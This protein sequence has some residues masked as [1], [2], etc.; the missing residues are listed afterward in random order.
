MFRRDGRY[1]VGRNGRMFLDHDSSRVVD[2]HTGRL[3]ISEP[4]L[5]A[6][7]RLLQR[8]VAALEPHGAAYAVLIPPN[9][10]SVYPEDLPRGVE[11][12]PSRPIHSLL[13]R[14]AA[15]GSPAPV[16]YPLAE[17]LE[18]KR[19]TEVYPR[20]E[21][22]WNE[23]GAFVAY[24][25]LLDA[26]P[27]SVPMRRLEEDQVWFFELS[28]PGDLGIKHRLPRKS[29]H[30]FGF[31]RHADAN[32]VADNRVEGTGNVLVTECRVAPAGTC[33]MFGDSY[34]F[35]LLPFLSESFRRLVFAQAPAV[36]VTLVARERPQMVLTVISERFLLNV[37]DDERELGFEERAQAKVAAGAVRPRMDRWDHPRHYSPAAVEWM[38][39][40]LLEEG[41]LEEATLLSVLA[42]AGLRP[43]EAQWLR[44]RDVNPGVLSVRTRPLDS[45]APAAPRHWP[46]RPVR[47]LEPL[48]Q[49]LAQ[50]RSATDAAEDGDLIFR[51]PFNGG[52]W[53]GGEWKRWTQE[54]YLPLVEQLGLEADGPGALR[55]T[56]I[57]LSIHAGVSAAELA[58]E[59]GDDPAATAAAYSNR[60]QE[61][62]RAGHVPAAVEIERARRL[63]AS[64]GLAPRT[65]RAL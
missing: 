29:P 62:A 47:L 1:V 35:G 54:R 34:A 56:F 16:V 52:V 22:H 7:T 13:S 41:R 40:R 20:T 30:V 24:R 2:Q 14:L 42:Y 39:A 8:R 25:A 50:W 27:A 55:L 49:D 18:R 21:T 15:Q 37:P 10:H 23:V 59:L 38:R 5:D 61:A 6:W 9:A 36:D 53:A 26:I 43:A 46:A 44:W 64:T 11:S 58:I 45:D 19:T 60:I 65:T 63:A 12:V 3:T 17:L 51:S 33:V 31:M 32:L 48:A 28:G 4:Q 57:A